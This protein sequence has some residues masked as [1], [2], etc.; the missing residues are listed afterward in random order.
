MDAAMLPAA[1]VGG[2]VVSKLVN[3][4]TN[5]AVKWRPVESAT[6]VATVTVYVVFACKAVVG[7]SVSTALPVVRLIVAGIAAPSGAVSVTFAAFTPF[8][9]EGS[10]DLEKRMT[11]GIDSG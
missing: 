2:G 5:G 6:P 1:G 3:R 11:T 4:A 8:T 7:R 9:V 10:I